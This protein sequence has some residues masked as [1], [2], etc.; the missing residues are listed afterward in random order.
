MKALVPASLTVSFCSY[1]LVL[2]FPSAGGSL[3]DECASF[4]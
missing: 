3:S 2:V 1:Q 4:N